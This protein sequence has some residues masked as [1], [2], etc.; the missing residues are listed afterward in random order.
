M[1]IPKASLRVHIHRTTAILYL[2]QLF[3]ALMGA[4][5]TV[6]ALLHADVSTPAW[7]TLLHIAFWATDFMG[8]AFAAILSYKI[9][10]LPALAPALTLG[11]YFSHFAGSISGTVPPSV[12][13]TADA[14]TPAAGGGG[15]NIGYMGYLIIALLLS[16]SIKY[17]NLCMGRL[18]RPW[19]RFLTKVTVKYK[20]M[21]K[22]DPKQ[23]AEGNSI[24]FNILLIPL[25]CAV[26][27]CFFVQYFIAAPF[28]SLADYLL[29]LLRNAWESSQALGGLF[30][31][32][33]VGFDTVG[34]VSM[35]AYRV[36]GDFAQLGNAVPMTVY[37]VSF[38]VVGWVV[39]GAVLLGGILKKGGAFD[40]DEGNFAVAGPFN[41]LAL[42]MKL[43][44]SFSM[45]YAYRY[46]ITSIVSYCA[47]G[48]VAGLIGGFGAIENSKYL[49]EVKLALIKGGEL[50]SVLESPFFSLSTNKHDPFMLLAL[51]CGILAGGAVV[52][53]LRE[54]V[55]K[56]RMAKNCYFETEG[57]IVGEMNEL[58]EALAA[59]ADAKR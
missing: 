57:N 10:G 3:G 12:L 38:T 21:R 51:L 37:C 18:N 30:S 4:V 45:S 59:E 7:N 47:G 40:K 31:G 5:V 6:A 44:V 16:Y 9:A 34:P 24:L 26:L 36:A 56:R 55:K 11:V 54:V 42:N 23:L 39:L 35:A 28:Q 27:T 13:Y 32:L 19:L 53:L 58:S 46:P 29:P 17:C 22:S 48:A 49:D 8:I 1:T 14:M 15:V 41:T 25:I 52:I 2:F 50:Y 33:M 20:A 43:T